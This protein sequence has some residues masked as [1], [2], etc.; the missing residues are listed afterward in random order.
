[1]PRSS[2]TERHSRSKRKSWATASGRRLSEANLAI[3]LTDLGRNEEAWSTSTARSPSCE[4]DWAPAIR[5]WRLISTIVARF[6]DSWAATAKRARSFELRARSGS[7]SLAPTTRF[8]RTRSLVSARAISLKELPIAPGATGTGIQESDGA[9]TESSRRAETG[10]PWRGHCGNR[11]EIALARAFWRRRP[12]PTTRSA[13]PPK[14][15]EVERWLGRST[16]SSH[17][18]MARR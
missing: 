18:R 1:M 4:R 13:A 12:E 15:A 8:W 9:G 2:S 6:S 7:G 11:T 17:A 10:S 5:I 14:L 3:A 16:D